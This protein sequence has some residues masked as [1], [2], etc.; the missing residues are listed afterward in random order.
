MSRQSQGVQAL[1]GHPT[2]PQP[3]P[4]PTRHLGILSWGGEAATGPHARLPRAETHSSGKENEA[5]G[6]Q[7]VSQKT[8]K[9]AKEMSA[10]EN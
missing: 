3:A 5:A 1:P 10:L 6:V 2:A 8:H 9:S 7:K 4:F